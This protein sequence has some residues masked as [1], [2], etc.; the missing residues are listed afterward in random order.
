MLLT[1]VF[2]VLAVLSGAL[3]LAVCGVLSPTA[4]IYN[5]E[6]IE[7]QFER[8]LFV[9]Y[10]LLTVGG[11]L[12]L[13]ARVRTS[14][15][16]HLR[17]ALVRAVARIPACWRRQLQICDTSLL[18][19]RRCLCSL[20]HAC[21]RGTVSEDEPQTAVGLET[22]LRQKTGLAV[23]G[24]DEGEDGQGGEIW[25][26]WGDRTVRSPYAPR[27]GLRLSTT[28]KSTWLF[29]ACAADAADSSVGPSSSMTT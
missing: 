2:G 22:G 10:L 27:D 1:D 16:A 19:A 23:G 28:I 29:V 7:G 15:V 6:L 5:L 24:A 11:V 20:C 12:A 14:G 3:A 4:P 18:G 26:D 21:G 25:G 17:R 13:L 8:P 9:A